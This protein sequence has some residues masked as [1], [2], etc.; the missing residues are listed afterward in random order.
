[1]FLTLVIIT[2]IKDCKQIGKENLAVPL[3]NRLISYFFSIPLPVILA[4]IFKNGG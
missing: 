4:L 1:M 2:Y 3:V